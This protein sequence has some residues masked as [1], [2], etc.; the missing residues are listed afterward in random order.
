MQPDIHAVSAN[1]HTLDL[2]FT[3]EY[4]LTT[5]MAL[6]IVIMYATQSVLRGVL[7]VN[8]SDFSGLP[9]WLGACLASIKGFQRSSRL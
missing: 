9:D 6:G 2:M 3:N 5:C 8:W 7:N 1:L 4:V